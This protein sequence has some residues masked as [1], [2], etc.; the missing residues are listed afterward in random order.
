MG[1]RRKNQKLEGE[2]MNKTIII[3]SSK[4][5]KAIGSLALILLLAIS[6]MMPFTQTSSAQVGV[7]QPEKTA[8]YISV[9]PTLIGVGQTATVNLWVFPLPTTYSYL[10]YFK[11]FT[12]IEV[13]FV[14]P[15]GTE[16]TFMPVDGTGQFVAGQSESLGSIYFYYEPDMAGNWSVTFTMPEQNVTD[17]SGTVIYTACTSKPAYFTVQTDPVNAGLLNGYPW[18]PLPAENTYWS[19]PINSN[20]REWSAISGDWLNIMNMANVQGTTSRHWQPYGSG[21]NTA[22]IVWSQPFQKGGIIGGDYGSFSYFSPTSTDKGALVIDGK[23]FY[24]ILNA[25]QF[26]CVDQ[27]TGK[28]LYT[29]DG[30]LIGAVHLPGNAYAQSMLDPSVVLGNS[31]GAAISGY[32][33]GTSGTTW[34]FYDPLTGK[35]VRS[36]VNC[37][38][39]RLVDGTNLGYGTRSGTLFAWDMSKVVNN[40]WP[41]G[42]NWTR[43]LPTPI[44]TARGVS[45]FGISADLSTVVLST[46]NQYWGFSAKDG[47]SLW[48]LTLTYPVAANEAIDLYGVNDFI[49]FDPTAATF[50]CYSMLTGA[51]LWE[52]ESFSDSPWATT[53]TV[54]NSETNDLENLYLAFPDGTIS[55]LSLKTGKQVWR[56]E[57]FASTEYTNNA[58]PFVYGCNL[59]GGNIYTFGGYSLGYGINPIPRQAMLVCINATTGDITYALNGGIYA[60]AAANGYIIGAGTYDG[61]MYCIGKGQTSTSVTI[62]NNVVTNHATALITGNVLDQSPAQAGTPAVADSAMSEWMDYLHM[63]NA[64]LLNNPPQEPGVPV[65][66]TAVDPNGNTINIGTTTTDSL[67]NYGINFVPTTTGMYTITAKFEGSDSYWPSTAGTKLT[68]L[69]A[70]QASATQSPIANPPYEL[71]TI[72]SAIAIIVAL[73]VVAVLL[74]RKKP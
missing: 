25:N 49:V 17:S 36:I 13:T 11:G 3:N 51:E 42:L 55:A 72:G 44:A 20:N 32:L 60:N 68:V 19:Y 4:S 61:N 70:P 16:D 22:H 45:L 71:Y 54:Y 5:K 74:L 9:A 39:A 67:G 69:E 64:T 66:L 57:A 63:Q 29:A 23:V 48:N 31:F 18:S 8:G 35:V 7:T 58:V 28:I 37:S 12:G 65:T 21:P 50:H 38:S 1:K 41:T 62:Q 34:N 59:A 53:W 43:P 2:R 73:A 40:N 27:A 33:Y 56:S 30:S 10:P 15:D 46:F 24:N 52:S 6:L 47:T 26:Q 14:K